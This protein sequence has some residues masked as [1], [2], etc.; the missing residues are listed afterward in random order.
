MYSPVKSAP[1]LANVTTSGE[2]PARASVQQEAMRPEFTISERTTAPLLKAEKPWESKSL[3]AFSVIR[4]ATGW[5]MW[6]AAYD[7]SYRNDNDALLCYARSDDGAKWTRPDLGLVEYN[8]SKD[9]NI[10]FDAR[11]AGG[12]HGQCVFLDPPAPAGERYKMVF[13][14]EPLGH[15]GWFVHGAVS[16]D[17]LHWT[18]LPEPLLQKNSDTQQACFWDGDRYRL[19]VRMWSGQE[20]L[21]TG[22]RQVGYTESAT[23]SAFPAPNVI[24][25]PDDQ[26][27]ADLHFYNSAASKLRDGLY[28][29]FPSAY[30]TGDHLV[31]PHL[32]MSRDGRNF[33]RIGR[34]PALPFGKAGG[35]DSKSIYVQPGAI[36]GERPNTWW[37][38]YIG[39][40]HG[41]ETKQSF[42]GGYGRFLLE[43]RD[44]KRE[45]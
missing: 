8:G 1:A 10:L 43:I 28:I 31:R 17:G 40:A 16:A 44:R 7:T 25:E 30:H 45:P 29:L 26:D 14:R 18:F 4:D 9:N 11:V 38:Y 32:A 2:V 15:G 36:P 23:F 13:V 21:Y 37:V 42:S 41:H 5:H 33:E 22:K 20:G 12:L 24:L 6:Y 19:Y 39:F 27:P 35:F 3:N 34:S